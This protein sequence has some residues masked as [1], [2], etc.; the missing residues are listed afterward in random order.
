MNSLV[1]RLPVDAHA[2]VKV[3]ALAMYLLQGTAAAAQAP[4]EWIGRGDG[5]AADQAA[6]AGMREGL[7]GVPGVGRVVIAEGEKDDAPMLYHG[8]QVGSGEGPEFDLA[9]DPL[10][11]TA[12]CADDADGAM[13][14][15]AAAPKGALWSSRNAW[16]MD[17]LVV[18]PDA[19]GSI[20]ME[21]P[22]EENLLAI[23]RATGKP[24]EHVTAIVLDKPRHV[25]LV[26]R[27]RRAGARVCLVPGG[28]VAGALRAVLPN[29]PVD[30]LMGVGGAPEGVIAACAV[31]LLGGEMQARLAP[32]SQPELQRVENA[33]HDIDAIMTVDDLVAS[34]SCCFLA[35]SVTWGDLQRRPVRTKTGWR[36]RSF[37]ST[38]LHPHLIVEAVSPQGAGRA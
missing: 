15:L 18:G 36:T 19:A 12:A 4:W 26:Q 31:R 27:I 33:G 13:A 35:T 21:R 30:V 23:A 11:N 37:V 28:D 8:E 2:G 5:K 7:V 24:I 10:E 38:P 16:Y 1:A 17:K 22:V 29:N 14:V 25:R 32:Q 3:P 6:V 34:D 20:D 9:V